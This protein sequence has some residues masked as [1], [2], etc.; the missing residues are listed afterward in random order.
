MRIGLLE[1]DHVDDRYRHLS[2]D[3]ADMFAALFA[4]D[5]IIELVNYDVVNGELP[6]EPGECDGWLV[7]GSRKSAYDDEE[8]IHRTAGFIRAA[9]ATETPLVGICFGHQL[10]AHAL[11][12]AVERAPAGWGA[13]ILTVDVTQKEPWMQPAR[14]EARLHFMHQ[15]QVTRVPNGGEVVASADHCPIA[16]FTVGDTMLGIQAHPEFTVPYAE[17][18]LT[19]RTERIGGD[20]A[21]AALESLATP[22]DEGV[23]AQWIVNFFTGARER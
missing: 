17:A 16:A 18:L 14:S 20:K 5:P 23:V 15:D 19:D 6:G 1:C 13:G 7:T 3:Y 2:G 11:E 12:G 21:G 8:W 9:A 10:L 22:T 4:A